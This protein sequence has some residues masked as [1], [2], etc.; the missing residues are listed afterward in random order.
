MKKQPLLLL[1]LAALMV[2]PALAQAVPRTVIN[3]TGSAT[4]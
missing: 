4:W 1:L 3:E 2:L